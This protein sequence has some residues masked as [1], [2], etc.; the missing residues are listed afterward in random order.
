MA[1]K[2]I[3]PFVDL[4][5]R[6]LLVEENSQPSMNERRTRERKQKAEGQG[7]KAKQNPI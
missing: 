7:R 4:G 3:F 1:L 5:W 2:E 6:V